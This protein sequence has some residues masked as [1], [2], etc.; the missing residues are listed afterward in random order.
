MNGV[1]RTDE[2]AATT[3]RTLVANAF[4]A[5]DFLRASLDAL[6]RNVLVADVDR[7][8]VFINEKA[9]ATLSAFDDRLRA[10]FGVGA[11]EI[12]GRSIHDFHR[13]PA[14]VDRILDA[15]DGLPHDAE[16]E[17]GGVRLRMSIGRV[18]SDGE[19]RGFV[20]DLED[21]TEASARRL[22]ADAL[23]AIS[24]EKE[25]Y[26]RIM[27]VVDAAAKGDFSLDLSDDGRDAVGAV[28]RRVRAFLAAIEDAFAEVDAGAETVAVA[29]SELTE[30]G[31][32]LS[33]SADASLRRADSVATAGAQIRDAIKNVASSSLKLGEEIRAIA[34]GATDALETATS[35]VAEVEAADR[36]MNVLSA[37]A[38]EIGEVSKSISAI[39][40]LTNMLAL[41]ATI[42]A[43]R[44]GD[45]G[46][47]FA[48]VAR[49]VK[50][51]AK[52]TGVATGNIGSRIVV[53]QKETAKAVEALARIRKTVEDIDRSQAEIS[54]AVGRHCAAATHVER[55]VAEVSQGA[56]EIERLVREAADASQKTSTD[57]KS[58]LKT[59]NE[60][61]EKARGLKS[62]VRR[63]RAT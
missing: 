36:V 59:A 54:E 60:V 5:P 2:L 11:D 12:L 3:T 31:E 52:R 14:A 51:L 30:A 19:T 47:G 8:V 21:V 6:P 23:R 55:G 53:I 22:Q 41:N 9:R 28:A 1:D 46:S 4:E 44:A 26:E 56:A 13:D 20:V 38:T 35:A 63:F 17:F 50:D 62:V 39:A 10:R 58:A 45:A 32:R 29:A 15:P 27:R 24:K 7:R 25:R 43:A 16:I 34:S 42:E 18:V 37:C 48:V 57:S 40:E 49:E 33:D 61:A